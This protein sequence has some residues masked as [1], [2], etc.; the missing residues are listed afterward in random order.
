MVR[1][2]DQTGSRTCRGGGHAELKEGSVRKRVREQEVL[3][4]SQKRMKPLC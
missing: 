1:G 3:D 4:T 2:I